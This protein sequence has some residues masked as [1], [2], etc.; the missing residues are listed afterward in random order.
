MADTTLLRCGDMASRFTGCIGAIVTTAA[1]AAYP[2]MVERSRTPGRSGMATAARLSCW[3]MRNRLASGDSVVVATL[4][5]Q[6]HGGVIH[7]QRYPTRSSGVADTA[8]L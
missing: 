2:S 1:V 5:A 3:N 6:G 8:L 4:T 7:L